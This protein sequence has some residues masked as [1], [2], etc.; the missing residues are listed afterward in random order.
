MNNI[1]TVLNEFSFECPMCQSEVEAN[2]DIVGRPVRC[3][4]CKVRV[5]V[6]E[7]DE[8]SI[9]YGIVCFD[10]PTFWVNHRKKILKMV[11]LWF[12]FALIGCVL[13]FLGI[14]TIWAVS[15]ESVKSHNRQIVRQLDEVDAFLAKNK[16]PSFRVLKAM[17]SEIVL[18]EDPDE[19]NRT[20]IA[21]TKK[22]LLDIYRN[23]E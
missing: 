18:I 16:E 15:S 11:F 9:P 12:P 3:K 2:A 8:D 1:V 23:K 6:P 21:A 17:A 5:Q 14:G 10:L 19:E 7:Q 13:L 22:R 20:R 4:N